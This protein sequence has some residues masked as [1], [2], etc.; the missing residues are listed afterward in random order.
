MS[1]R[2]NPDAALI[3]DLASDST[4]GPLIAGT[5][6]DGAVRGTLKERYFSE[7]AP[8]AG[9]RWWVMLAITRSSSSETASRRPSPGA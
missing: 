2:T 5:T 1:W 3:A 4:T 6:P 9:G 8:G 7:E